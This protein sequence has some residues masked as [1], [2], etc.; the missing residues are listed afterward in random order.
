MAFHPVTQ[1]NQFSAHFL[2]GFS[3]QDASRLLPCFQHLSGQILLLLQD[4]QPASIKFVPEF[5][6]IAVQFFFIPIQA[7]D[8]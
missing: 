5:D 8:Q 4:S 6:S 1:S 3:V 7:Y 2:E